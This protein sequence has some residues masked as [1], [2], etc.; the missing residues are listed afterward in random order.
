MN[1]ELYV[2]EVMLKGSGI[3]VLDAVR[4]VRQILDFKVEDDSLKAMPFCSQVIQVG[5]VHWQ[6]QEM[7]VLEGFERYVATK[8]HL[9]ADS[10]RDIKY[11]GGRLLRLCPELGKRHFSELSRGDC[12]RWLSAAFTTPSQFNKGRALLHAL[13]EFAL[14]HEW[15]DRNVVK[16]VQKK[17]V[18]EQEIKPLSMPESQALLR[19]AKRVAGGSCAAGVGLLLLAGLRPTELRRLRWGDVDWA[20][21]SLTVR[22]QCSKTGGV[23]QVELGEALLRY[24]KPYRKGAT[25]LICPPDWLPLWR[26]IREAAGFK[27]R[28]VQDVLRHTYA[29]YHAKRFRDL[30]LLQLNMGHRDLSLLR[31]R[32]VN[33]GGISAGD[34]KRYFTMAS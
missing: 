33:M 18:I 6:R 21:A 26:T 23:R 29:S 27:G 16:L 31:A 34:A 4:L 14:R 22:A 25:D 10:L 8:G 24:L 7:R 9:R 13:V 30:P 12:E 2:A 5:L 28:W 3:S 20:E 15:C 1:D 17:R 32:Y 19:E 11:L